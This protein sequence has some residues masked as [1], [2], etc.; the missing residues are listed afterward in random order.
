MGMTPKENYLAALRHEAYEFIP[1]P[2][3]DCV[4]VGFGAASGPA[5][6]KGPLGGGYDGFGVR[7][8]NPESGGGA[9]IPAPG[10]F[11]LD[12]ETIVDWKR[13]VKFPDLAAFDWES[14]AKMELSMGNPEV[15]CIEFGSGNG[16][17]ERLAAMMGFEEALMALALEPEASYDFMNAVVDYKID[18]LEYVKKY[19]HAEVFTNYDDI[20]TEQCTFM[21]PETYRELIKPLHKKLNDAVY[22]SGMLP[23]QHTCGKADALIE[24]F[25][26]TGAAAWTS[27]QPTNDIA[28]ILQKYGSQICISGGFDS[29]GRP[30]RPETTDEEVRAE[31]RRCMDEYGK[32][33]GYM[34]FGFRL[35]KSLDPQVNLAALM[36]MLQEAESY[37]KGIKLDGL[38]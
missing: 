33:R 12:T 16:P 28:A 36:P 8:V 19:Y 35:T 27:V 15:Q 13:R 23:V 24:D 34:F 29:N 1:S 3:N 5:F 37:R 17:F 14:Q 18:T 10:E 4:M 6:E 30:A 7:W 31:V 20:A 32:Y 21:A 9:P 11:L 22:A 2:V 26:E 25:I 38:F